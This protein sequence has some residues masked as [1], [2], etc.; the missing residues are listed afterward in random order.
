MEE[1]L[2]GEADSSSANQEIPR[3]LRNPKMHYRVHNSPPFVSVLRQI[4]PV[5]VS[6][7]MFWKLTLLLLLLLLLLLS[8]LSVIVLYT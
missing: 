8:H 7:I 2:S 6:H 3:T 4:D 5:H 1:S